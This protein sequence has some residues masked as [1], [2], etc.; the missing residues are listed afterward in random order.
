MRKK[1]REEADDYE[2]KIAKKNPK[3]A[4]EGEEGEDREEGSGD[5]E[6]DED[7][8]ERQKAK[9]EEQK[10]KDKQRSLQKVGIIGHYLSSKPM[11]YNMDNDKLEP[12]KDD[13]KPKKL[14]DLNIVKKGH[15]VHN[16]Y[17]SRIPEDKQLMEDGYLR[18]EEDRIGKAEKEAERLRKLEEAKRKDEKE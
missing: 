12:P 17:A 4:E 5:E 14:I 18:A 11:V 3:E 13:G 2:K 15:R 8:K 1:N 7:E 6:V 16:K 9:K 10:N